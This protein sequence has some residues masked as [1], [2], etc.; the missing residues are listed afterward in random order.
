MKSFKIVPMDIESDKSQIS[1]WDLLY[2][3]SQN[4]LPIYK[5]IL[6]NGAITGLGEIIQTNYEHFP[7]GRN[8][9]KFAF[10][11]KANDGEIV[12]FLIMSAFDLQS[13]KPE[14][15]LQ[16]VVVNP[17][18]QHKGYGTE[19]LKELFSNFK[20]YISVRPKNIFSYVH[21]ENEAS[22]HLFNHFGFELNP[23]PKSEYFC[24]ETDGK[25][26]KQNLQS[27]IENI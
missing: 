8:E 14:L 4:Y 20:K 12:G 6:E 10:V 18:Y 15:F 19:M 17:K 13:S 7:I 23:V 24:A 21:V 9:R 1:N 22:K 2:H 3:G 27:Q 16:Y 26:L 11:A 5:F 25:S